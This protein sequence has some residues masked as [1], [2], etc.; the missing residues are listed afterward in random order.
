MVFIK[1]PPKFV[2]QRLQVGTEGDTVRLECRVEAIPKPERIVW[3]HH[4]REVD[5]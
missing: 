5:E 3:S 4:G 2:S 1:G